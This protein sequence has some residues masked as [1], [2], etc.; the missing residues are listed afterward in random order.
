M[1][2]RTTLQCS[3]WYDGMLTL[4][5]QQDCLYNW[6]YNLH[7][8]GDDVEI[9]L[10][11]DPTAIKTLQLFSPIRTTI[12]DLRYLVQAAKQTLS[13]DI[14][15]LYNNYKSTSINSVMGNYPQFSLFFLDCNQVRKK[16]KKTHGTQNYPSWCTTQ[17]T[18]K[19]NL[20]WVVR[21]VN[22]Y[23]AVRGL[24]PHLFPLWGLFF[25]LCGLSFRVYADFL[26]SWWDKKKKPI[27]N[28]QQTLCRLTSAKTR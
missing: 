14:L 16:K 20:T 27:H 7:D 23:P 3:S 26:P 21:R 5:Y 1:R 13:S 11:Y 22:S 10:S 19:K 9:H 6:M 17:Y 25:H 18:T 12:P 28:K 2:L 8:G 15:T 24:N 4:L